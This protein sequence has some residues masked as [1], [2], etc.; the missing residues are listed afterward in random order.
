MDWDIANLV[1]LE[2]SPS[3]PSWRRAS[4]KTANLSSKTLYEKDNKDIPQPQ[5]N[6]TI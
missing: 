5:L 3:S 1:H 6:L 2:P 4:K